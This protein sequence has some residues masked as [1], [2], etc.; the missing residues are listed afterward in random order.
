MLD[1]LRARVSRT[2]KTLLS[3]FSHTLS[4]GSLQLKRESSAAGASEQRGKVGLPKLVQLRQLV[5]RQN[6]DRTTGSPISCK[7]SD[8]TNDALATPYPALLSRNCA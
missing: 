6:S 8:Q 5:H 4:I 3:F 2:R 1:V 7:T